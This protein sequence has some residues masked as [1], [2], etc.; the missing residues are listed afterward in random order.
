MIY[1]STLL[2]PIEKKKMALSDRTYHILLSTLYWIE[3]V[4]TDF[5]IPT[6]IAPTNVQ[7]DA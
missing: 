7:L 1:S 4:N 6:F 2:K 3:L 5:V